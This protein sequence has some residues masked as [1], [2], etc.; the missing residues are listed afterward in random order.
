MVIEKQEHKA[1]QHAL[2]AIANWM[3]PPT[4]NE[5]INYAIARLGSFPSDQK[6][7]IGGG[8]TSIFTPSG[9]RGT[10]SDRKSVV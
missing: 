3:R 4:G 7:F 2:D 9:P 1:T 8:D 6:S 10:L 5:G